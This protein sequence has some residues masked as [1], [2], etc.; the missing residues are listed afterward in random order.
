MMSGAC[1][2]IASVRTFV[3]EEVQMQCD[4]RI[5][6]KNCFIRCLVD[7]MLHAN[8]NYCYSLT[9]PASSATLLHANDWYSGLFASDLHVC[10]IRLAPMPGM[11]K[12][13][14]PSLLNFRAYHADIISAT[15]WHIAQTDVNCIA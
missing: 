11:P 3:T 7:R 6:I 15:C 13:H 5:A 8:G 4:S 10:C 1:Y 9:T 2:G 14:A 12:L